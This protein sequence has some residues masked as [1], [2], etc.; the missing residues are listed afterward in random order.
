M[1]ILKVLFIVVYS[2]LF[3][4]IEFDL[5]AAYRRNSRPLYITIFLLNVVAYVTLFVYLN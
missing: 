1:A 3:V 4:S 2:I 5:L